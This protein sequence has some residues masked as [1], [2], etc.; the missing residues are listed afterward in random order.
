MADEEGEA[1]ELGRA[2]ANV[3]T[4]DGQFGVLRERNIDFKV[5][6]RV[7]FFPERFA[8]AL[9]FGRFEVEAVPAP[10]HRRSSRPMCLVVTLG[11]RELGIAKRSGCDRIG[12]PVEIERFPDSAVTP[13][14]DQRKG[15]VGRQLDLVANVGDPEAHLRCLLRLNFAVFVV[16]EAKRPVVP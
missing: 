10:A 13:F 5:A 8:D 2:F 9:V 1:R 6:Q 4:I 11:S 7:V 3:D 16:A 12:M 15:P 14:V